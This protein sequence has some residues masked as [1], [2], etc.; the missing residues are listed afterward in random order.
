VIL[1][2]TVVKPETKGFL[3]IRP[4]DASG[5]P[6]TSNINWDAGS[7]NIANSVTV[8]LPASGQ[9]DI[10]VNGTVGSVLIDVAGYMLPATSGPAGP[11]GPAGADGPTGPAGADGAKGDTG[12]PGPSGTAGPVTMSHGAGPIAVLSAEQPAKAVNLSYGSVQVVNS[13]NFTSNSV[14]PLHGPAV[15][16]GKTYKLDS[17]EYCITPQPG[18]AVFFANI[19]SN[20]PVGLVI[21]TTVRDTPGC[22][23]IDGSGLPAAQGY[24]VSFS[25]SGPEDS[26]VTFEGVQSTWVEV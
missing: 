18:T 1:N 11:T 17:V 15:L 20:T 24:H 14:L 23:S 9:I 21:D 2:A 8:Q 12:P 3:S 25:T 16:G 4:G 19:D 5:T 6:A 13:S 22:Y 7:A 10:F 26:F